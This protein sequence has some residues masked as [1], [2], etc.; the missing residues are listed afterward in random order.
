M[1]N[2]Q[3]P[4][5]ATPE[6]RLERV[7][8]QLHR[9]EADLAKTQAQAAELEAQVAER[10]AAAAVEA[11]VEQLRADNPPAE[12]ADRGY[13]VGQWAGR[14]RYYSTFDHADFA[15]EEAAREYARQSGH[16]G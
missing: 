12:T 8:S 15:T 14:P 16:G 11:H 1:P 10:Q 4:Q 6:N 13:I 5:S 9:T 3:Q 7:E 2:K